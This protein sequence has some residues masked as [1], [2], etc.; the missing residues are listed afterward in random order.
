M[1]VEIVPGPDREAV[2]AAVREA[3]HR[4]IERLGW[5]VFLQQRG[6]DGVIR[7]LRMC[8][9]CRT[10]WHDRASCPHPECHGLYAA[11]T[12]HDAFDRL[13][14]EHPEGDVLAVRTGR[15]SGIF[16]VDFDLKHDAP[17]AY[18][19]WGEA[20]GHEWTFPATLRQRTKSGGFHLV[21]RLPETGGDDGGPPV[22]RSRNAVTLRGVDVKAEGGLFVVDPTPG[23][24]WVERRLP[25]EPGDDV[26]RWALDAPVHRSAKR[27]ARTS[28]PLVGRLGRSAGGRSPGGVDL[29]SASLVGCPA[30]ERDWYVNA[31]CFALRVA[32]TPWDEA[33]EI[34]R[35]EWSHL[36]HPAGDEFRWEW[37]L[38]K[39]E[40]VWRDVAPDP[41]VA[42]GTRWARGAAAGER[43]TNPAPGERVQ[44]GRKTIVRR[45]A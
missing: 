24:E 10:T 11:T 16:V 4:Y 32:D 21:Y 8:D 25:A 36:E 6:P 26:L 14:R 29:R 45:G 9:A 27:A 43:S 18:D 37:C 38:Y 30:G 28:S 12:D 17:A 5:A 41:G 22:V 7:S 31:V 3:G 23:Y 15:A 13:W 42:A 2:R 44:V 20:T 34:L 19:A 40:R 33:V 39:L 1:V 35:D